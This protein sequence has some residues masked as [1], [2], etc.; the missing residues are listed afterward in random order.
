MAGAEYGAMTPV[1]CRSRR[2]A[3]RV[4]SYQSNT[5]GVAVVLAVLMAASADAQSDSR[6]ERCRREAQEISGY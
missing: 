1:V 6:Y 4:T 3:R 2:G 5:A